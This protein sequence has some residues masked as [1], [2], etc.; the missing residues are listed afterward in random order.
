LEDYKDLALGVN[1]VY[2]AVVS[3]TSGGGGASVTV[4]PLPYVSDYLT[5]VAN[6]ISISSDLRTL[7]ADTINPKKVLGTT[8]SV[9][10]SIVVNKLNISLDVKVSDNYV[11][12]WVKSDVSDAIDS[13]FSFNYVDFGKEIR[14]AD[15]Y[16][17]VMA[18]EGVDYCT[19]TTFQMY[20][21]SNTPISTGSLSPVELLKKGTV[22]VTT[23][24]GMTT[25]A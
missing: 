20:D 25:S 5:L 23:T 11:A 7:V 12:A 19:I 9:A 24:G 18:V 6:S 17:L 4:Y 16:K 10:S 22:V 13:L 14:V 21:P 2:R 1:G 15:V 3:Y 8:L